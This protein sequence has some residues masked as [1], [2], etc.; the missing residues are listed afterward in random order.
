MPP[1]PLTTGKVFHRLVRD[2]ISRGSVRLPGR[3]A[4]ARVGHL[5]AHLPAV[6]VR[7]FETTLNDSDA[8]C[9]DGRQTVQSCGRHTGLAETDMRHVARRTL[10]DASPICENRV[11][12]TRFSVPM[13][14]TR[15]SV[16]LIPHTLLKE[17][18]LRL[19]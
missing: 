8:L 3:M 19:T 18:L 10:S 15:F 7:S 11:T 13:T 14:L 4:R 5:A 1:K 9:L 16:P 12:L 2:W 17:D 6:T